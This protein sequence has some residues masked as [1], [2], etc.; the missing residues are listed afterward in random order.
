MTTVFQ[1]IYRTLCFD[2]GTLTY[3]PWAQETI[4]LATQLLGA[5]SGQVIETCRCR[6]TLH[7]SIA[8]SGT[9]ATWTPG[10]RLPNG[11]SLHNLEARLELGL[12]GDGSP[13][14]A[15]RYRD[16]RVGPVDSRL[17]VACGHAQRSSDAS[18]HLDF[19][20]TFCDTTARIHEPICCRD[21]RSTID[22]GMVPV[23]Q[24]S[25]IRSSRKYHLAIAGHVMFCMACWVAG[26]MAACTPCSTAISSAWLR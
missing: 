12:R 25:T 4:A 15:S 13:I 19:W 23:C 21:L 9:A 6:K 24:I 10:C 18:V 22:S 5:E 2:L 14:L 8:D 11:Q 26:L 16:Q 1:W 3:R 20:A 7:L 17:P